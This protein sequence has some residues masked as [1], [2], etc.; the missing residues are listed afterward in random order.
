MMYN[1]MSILLMA[2]PKEGES[3]FMSFIPLLLI[4][5]VFY[6]FMIR[7]QIKK[8]KESRKYRE[9]LKAGDSVV[10]VG[11]IFG[12]I[13]EVKEDAAIIEVENKVRLKVSKSA[14]GRDASNVITKK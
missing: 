8:Q 9:Q 13:V 1:L 10:T 2:P 3:P 4:I 11:G 12:K 7:P 6:F 14:L 5:V